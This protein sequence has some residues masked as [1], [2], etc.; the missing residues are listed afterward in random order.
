LPVIVNKN[1]AV[2][3]N[4]KTILAAGAFFLAAVFGRSQQIPM[5]AKVFKSVE[6]FPPPHAQQVKSRVSGAT[7][8][9]L[10]GNQF[11]ITELT[12][13]MYD[14][15][16][17]LQFVITAPQ[18]FFDPFHGEANSPGELHV[19]TGDN[20]MRV[21]GKGFLWRRSDS[22]ITISNNVQTVFEK[23]PAVAPQ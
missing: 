20:T 3:N 15:N 22:S 4:W 16:G 5:Q 2:T 10:S 12:L 23:F 9:Q 11:L 6:Y 8:Q 17:D 14:E 1:L 21:D 19:H 18:C 13:E 7:A